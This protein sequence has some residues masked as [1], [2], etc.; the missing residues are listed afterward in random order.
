MSPTRETSP[1]WQLAKSLV[2]TS[3]PYLLGKEVAE[4]KNMITI[5]PQVDQRRVE[6]LVAELDDE[7]NLV[8]QN[9][10]RYS[11]R[12]F[13]IEEFVAIHA[14]VAEKLCRDEECSCYLAGR[15]HGHEDVFNDPS[16]YR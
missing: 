16:R 2:R 3:V 12:L 5:P 6:Q 4:E 8:T 15:E 9:Y 11:G 1:Y 13:T 14:Y 10:V 7:N